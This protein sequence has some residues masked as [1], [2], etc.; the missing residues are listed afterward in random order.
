MPIDSGSVTVLERPKV[1]RI[2]RSSG[3]RKVGDSSKLRRSTKQSSSIN[4]L[5]NENG[6]KSSVSSSKN[7]L[8][9]FLS[10]LKNYII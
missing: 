1:D 10:L 6:S 2:T 5:S 3:T 9:H 8:V 7:N 4:L